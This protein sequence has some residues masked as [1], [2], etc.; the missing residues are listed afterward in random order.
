MPEARSAGRS[1]LAS[2][3]MK[4]RM[5]LP[6]VMMASRSMAISA[7]GA[8]CAMALRASAK[9]RTDSAP[10]SSTSPRRARLGTASSVGSRCRGRSA[11]SWDWNLPSSQRTSAPASGHISSRPSRLNWVWNSASTSA[12]DAGP[13]PGS[14]TPASSTA[15]QTSGLS[16]PAA[17]TPA[18]RLKATWAS[19]TRRAAAVAPMATRPAVEV[20]PIL[21]PTMMAAAGT[22]A[23]PPLAVA[24]MVMTTTAL[25]DWVTRVS[26]M[27]RASASSTTSGPSPVMAGS[28]SAMPAKPLDRMPMPRK[29]SPKPETAP[30]SPTRRDRLRPSSAKAMPSPIM[31]RASAAMSS[32]TP[33]SATSQ[34]VM[35]LPT[36]VPKISHTACVRLSM[37]ALTKPMVATVTAV[38]D[39]TIAVT[40]TPASRPR[41]ALLVQR[42]SR[43]RSEGPAAILRPSVSRAMPSRNSPS[44]PIRAASGCMSMSMHVGRNGPQANCT[45]FLSPRTCA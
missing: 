32:L 26:R 2:R 40:S 16:R 11:V 7:G 10:I 20:V 37:P 33:M 31:G 8:P 13:A 28:W 4:S 24:V 12:G 34:P 30:P 43:F 29:N 14:M 18:T 9:A 21:L 6:M 3:A 35:V 5:L 41:G 17:T 36:L 45:A 38:E 22:S 42:L 25:E 19:A 1:A 44:P 15:S 27:P 39:C 23:R